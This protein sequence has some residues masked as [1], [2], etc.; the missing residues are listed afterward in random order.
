MTFIVAVIQD[1]PVVF[2]LD[3][4]IDK[5]EDLTQKAANK[6]AELVVFPEAFI[7]AYP[8]GLDFGARIGMRSKEGREMFTKYY[9]SALEM[10]SNHYKKLCSIAKYNKIMI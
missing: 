1:S 2:N 7:S 6:N 5:I 9:N 10:N 8:K 4:T 3:A